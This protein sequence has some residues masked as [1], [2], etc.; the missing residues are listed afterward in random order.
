MPLR[1]TYS[2]PYDWLFPFG[3]YADGYHKHTFNSKLKVSPGVQRNIQV[4]DFNV[5]RRFLNDV[6]SC[7]KRVIFQS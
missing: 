3:K 1:S 2:I 4:V 6:G 5:L 7:W